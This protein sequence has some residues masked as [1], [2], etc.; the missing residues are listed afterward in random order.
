[1]L[2]RDYKKLIAKVNDNATLFYNLAYCLIVIDEIDEGLKY[3]Q[4]AIEINK[5]V[6][7]QSKR[8]RFFEKVWENPKYIEINNQYKNSD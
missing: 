4:K 5:K 6:I 8:D 2:I 7:K 1:L 3:Y